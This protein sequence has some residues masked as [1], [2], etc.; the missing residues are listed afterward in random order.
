MRLDGVDLS[1]SIDTVDLI[2]LSTIES[3]V[4]KVFE[5]SVHHFSYRLVRKLNSM[6][7]KLRDSNHLSLSN[8]PKEVIM[9]Q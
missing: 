2:S 1:L 5:I 3:F 7:V 9:G 4:R 6:L 8:I